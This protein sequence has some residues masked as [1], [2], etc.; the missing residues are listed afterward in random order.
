VSAG[1]KFDLCACGQR[2]QERSQKCRACYLAE[3]GEH[4]RQPGQMRYFLHAGDPG[5]GRI[6][7]DC[8]GP[9]EPKS[10]RCWSCRGHGPKPISGDAL[11]ARG[12]LE[13]IVTFLAADGRMR[14]IHCFGRGKPAQIAYGIRQLPPGE[15]EP[16]C[17]STPDSILRDLQ[18]TAA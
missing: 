7:P 2:K 13:S 3:L 11:H 6:C 4:A 9:K 10:R 8:G 15:W 12:R 18:K 16:I 14:S 1:A 5:Y 17:R